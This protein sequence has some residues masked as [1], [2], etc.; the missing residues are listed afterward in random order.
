MTGAVAVPK[1]AALL[2]APFPIDQA[3]AG[4]EMVVSSGDTIVVVK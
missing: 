4:G 2:D 3:G 1:V